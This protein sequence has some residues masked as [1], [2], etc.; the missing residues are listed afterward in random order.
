[1]NLIISKFLNCNVSIIGVVINTYTKRTRQFLPNFK[2]NGTSRERRLFAAAKLLVWLDWELAQGNS[3]NSPMNQ[4]Q[5]E[6][7]PMTL[8]RPRHQ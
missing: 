3:F 4:P 1:M 8:Y 6:P 5:P 2:I 7:H